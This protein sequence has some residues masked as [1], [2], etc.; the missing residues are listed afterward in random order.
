MGITNINL[1][2]MSPAL[3]GNQIVSINEVNLIKKLRLSNIMVHTVNQNST[4][5]AHP[6]WLF[7]DVDK[8]EEVSNGLHASHSFCAWWMGSI[9]KWFIWSKGCHV[10]I[11]LVSVLAGRNAVIIEPWISYVLAMLAIQYWGHG[12]ILVD[13]TIMAH[14]NQW[15]KLLYNTP[16]CREYVVV[17]VH[18]CMEPSLMLY[19]INH[20]YLIP[21][22]WASLQSVIYYTTIEPSWIIENVQFFVILI[23]YYT[24]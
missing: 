5:P 10:E 18:R 6:W 17:H 16:F 9:H 8:D 4:F 3:C 2:T 23:V 24:V 1:V 13:R 14:G 20:F 11:D 7:I 15:L 21:A 12:N 22:L 19:M